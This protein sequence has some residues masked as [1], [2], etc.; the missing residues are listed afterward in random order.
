MTPHLTHEQLCDLLISN[1]A[2]DS[3][4]FASQEVETAREHVRDCHVCAGEFAML[5]SSLKLFR[6]TADAWASHEWNHQSL[7]QR[8]PRKPAPDR[9]FAGVLSRPVIWATAAAAAIA[10]AVPFSLHQLEGKKAPAA[11]A[12]T[13]TQPYAVETQHQSDEAL[14]EEISQTV[15]YSVPTPMQPLADPT[16]SETGNTQRKN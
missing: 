11:A 14:L 16:A 4:A 10:V 15:S 7:L 2:N 9:R 5:D 1:R 13:L 3:R 6:S 12:V 8:S